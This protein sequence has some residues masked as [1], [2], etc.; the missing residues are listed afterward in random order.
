[1]QK[2]KGTRDLLFTEIEKWKILENKIKIYLEKYNF[3]EIRTPIL[4]YCELFQRSAQYSEMVMKEI[5]QFKDK[6]GRNIALRP[7]GTA[8]IA[9]SYVENKLYNTND[10]TKFYYY[11]PFFRYER[12]QKG[13]YRQ[14]HQFG[15]E[16][17]G[18][19]N[20]LSEIEIFFLLS[21]LLNILNLK[22]AKIKI[23]SLG[24]LESRNRFLNDFKPYITNHQNELC[25]LCL[26][27]K[28]QNILRIF[29]CKEC[30]SKAILKEAP[31]IFNYLTH[32]S[33]NKF[34]T[35]LDIL[36]KSQINFEIDFQLVRGLDYY[37]D[38][39]FEISIFSHINKQNY[40]LGG[41]GNYNNL[42]KEF[43]GYE[44]KSIGFAFGIERLMD[45]LEENMFFENYKKEYGLDVYLFN[46]NEMIMLDTFLLLR[47]IRQNNIKA[48]MNYKI[49]NFKKQFRKILELKPKYIIFIGPKEIENNKVNIKNIS[50]QTTFTINKN[51]IINFLKEG[52]NL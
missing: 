36:G 26:T 24:D 27:R 41:G 37:T 7:E 49:F 39:V 12:P 10:L 45:I 31:I 51:K 19:K 3:Q 20:F 2:I 42:I 23:N 47:K 46:L 43:S 18:I 50:D 22:E 14:F 25:N 32:E 40:I 21:D 52:L 30:S 13:R 29:D 48:E 9:R 16:V 11:G 15:V 34:Q 1:M 8:S 28:D 44:I 38:L 5:F 33:K 35:T 6:K 4:E 17:I